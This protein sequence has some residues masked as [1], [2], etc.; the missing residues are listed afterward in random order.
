MSLRYLRLTCCVAVAAVCVPLAAPR[1]QSCPRE[2]VA[3]VGRVTVWRDAGKTALLFA[4]GLAIDADGAPD[5]YHP[6]DR[7]TDHLANAGKPG[8]WWGL[9]TEN[10]Q[11]VV[12][13][14]DDPKP[15]YYVSTTALVDPSKPARSPSRYVDSSRIPYLALPPAVLSS[16]LAGGARLGDFAAVVNTA[17]GR[18]A[19]A[20]I[21][22]VGPKDKIGEGSIALADAL[23]VSS[24]PK[25]GGASRG[26]AVAVFPGSGNGRP[27]S[28]EEVRAEGARL[29]AGFGGAGRVEACTAK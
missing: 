3:T 14:P 25:R 1:A 6:D 5:A 15:G 26:I 28:L 13:G 27:R 16:R 10:G 2:A 18:V 17:T 22:D 19:F 23:G 24:S 9:A 4:G 12:Q 21:A 29:L 20:L 11:P 7:G 8:N